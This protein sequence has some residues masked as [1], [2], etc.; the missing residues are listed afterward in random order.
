MDD[1]YIHFELDGRKLKINK[2]NPDDILM[3]K[4]HCSRGEM[5][6]PRWNQ[7]KIQTRKSDGYKL[8]NIKPTIYYLHRVNYYAHNQDWD[9]HDSSMDNFID[10]EDIDI[11]NNNIENLRV[12]THQENQFNTNAKGYYW[13]KK[14]QKWQ[15]YIKVNDKCKYLGLFENEEDAH[16]AYLEAKKIHHIIK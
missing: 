10:H 2:E 6:K 16:Q 13:H 7:I 8:I 15:A 12:V 9:I 4:T 5:K 11:T 1:N 3:L 14:A